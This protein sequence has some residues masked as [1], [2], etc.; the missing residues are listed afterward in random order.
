LVA[1]VGAPAAPATTRDD[2]ADATAFLVS[3]QT[4]GGGFAEQGGAADASLTAWVV[5]ALAASGRD[6]ATVENAGRSPTHF[7]TGKPY[8]TATDLELRILALDA[9]GRAATALSLA[10]QLE[11]LRR[12]SGSI[13][14]SV[15]STIWGIL[16]LRTVDRPAGATAVSFLLR[17]QRRDG[18]W[19]WSTGA[20]AD[21]ND[22]AAAIQA[23]RAAGVSARSRAVQR[24]LAFL[25]RLRNADGGFE[26]S[27]GRGS[28][29]Q[30]TAWAIQAFLAAGNDPPTGA[31]A[32]LGR[33][34]RP[35][36]S[37]R[38]SARFVTTPVWVTATVLP[39]L[40]RRPF[41]L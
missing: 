26:L 9:L 14:P 20:A 32:Y 4:A 12:P 19:S 30:S 18:G 6:P 28:D 33:L 23:L 29:A 39:A 40:S 7:L 36:G 16:A 22:T 24:G 38:Y 17:H 41:P 11:S 31:F 10:E 3:H 21:S 1:L 25:R 15:N 5:L 8:P 27:P 2:R 13:G 37:Y 34:R 35:D